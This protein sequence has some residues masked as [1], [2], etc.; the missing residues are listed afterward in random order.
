VILQHLQAAIEAISR[1][2]L[3]II[4]LFWINTSFVSNAW[5]SMIDYCFSKAGRG[6][7]MAIVLFLRLCERQMRRCHFRRSL[8]DS[9]AII[10]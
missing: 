9:T 2:I 5:S 3:L 1:E 8:D 4:E 6:L 7:V 10:E